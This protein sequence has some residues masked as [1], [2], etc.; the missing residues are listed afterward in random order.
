LHTNY[1]VDI[2]HQV[3]RCFDDADRVVDII[4]RLARDPSIDA[5]L[6]T[7]H[8]GDEYAVHPTEAQRDLA[9]Q[10]LDAGALAV[11]GTHPHV[12]QPWEKYLTRD[13]RETLVVYSLGNFVS[14]MRTQI[15][16][17][18]VVLHL[19]LGRASDGAVRLRGV[20]YLPIEV[21]RRGSRYRVE[22]MRPFQSPGSAWK[23]V[24]EALGRWNWIGPDDTL[25]LHPHCDA[26]WVPV[27]LPGT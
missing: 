17:T 16:R 18:S 23:A 10:L 7:P 1:Q 21:R 14:R 24:A 11:L 13:G 5:I 22:P 8:W 15:R 2:H 4:T 19:G 27:P 20:S 9:H 25:D 26:A 3:L 12:L 6:V